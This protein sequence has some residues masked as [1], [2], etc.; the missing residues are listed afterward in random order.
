MMI[1]K[2]LSGPLLVLLLAGCQ[3]NYLVYVQETSLGLTIAASTEGSNKM[4]L[5]YDRDV[6]AIVPKKTEDSDAM[7]LFSVNKVKVTGL[8]DM[9][10]SEFVASG[11]AADK[12]AES[13]N[14]INQLR[15][16]VYGEI[17]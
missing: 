16:K 14:S 15:E 8:D 3:S 13:A 1:Y 6:Y 5:G 4:S 11:E 10:V 2:R 7:S 17:K 12:L 9:E